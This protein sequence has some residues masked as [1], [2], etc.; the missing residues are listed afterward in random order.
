MAAN[1]AGGTH[2]AYADHGEGYCVFNDVA[3]AARVM[4]AEGRVRRVVVLDCDVHQ[5]NGT[6]SI[7]DG[8]DSVFTFSIHGEK[9]FPFHKEK[10]ALDIGLPDGTGDEAYLEALLGGIRQSLERARADLALYLAGS[11]PYMD[12]RL[13]R[14]SLSKD[15]LAER[16]RLVFEACRNSGLP[17]AITMAGGYARQ[18]DD[19]V[20][21][22]FQTIRIAVELVQREVKRYDRL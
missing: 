17:V 1:L 11:D 5:G 2:H 21:I 3:V 19:S 4:Q 9:N 8:D 18:I 22:H 15:G 14:L 12:D 16:D 13:G 7:F 10:S 6:A 20:D